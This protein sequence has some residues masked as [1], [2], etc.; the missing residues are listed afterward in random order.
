[1]DNRPIGIFDSGVGGLTVY[2]EIKSK[3]PNEDFI[4]LGDTKRFPYGSKTKEN[5]IEIS[6][7]CIN[8]L[9]SQNVKLIIIACGTATSQALNELKEIYEIPI[10]GIIEP[11]AKYIRDKQLKNIGVIATRGTINSNSWEINIK[12]ESPDANVYNKACPLLA[13]MVEEG[14]TNNAIARLAINEYLEGFTDIENLDSL[15][16]GCTHYPLFTD[17][18]RDVLPNIDIIN[19]GKVLANSLDTMFDRTDKE[20]EGYTTFCLTDIESNFQ[21]L[22]RNILKQDIQINLVN[23]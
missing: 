14:W 22:A 18:I 11:T 7:N 5:I 20:I 21:H 2:K 23:I 9:I 12:Q 16:L 3:F 13:S 15:V 1:M 10:I 17:L 8:Y 19:T 4:Y 6:K